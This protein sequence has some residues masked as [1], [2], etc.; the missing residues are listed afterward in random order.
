VAG[1]ERVHVAVLGP[2]VDEVLEGAS[3]IDSAG[4]NGLG[5][6]D[7]PEVDGPQ[8]VKA[9]GVAH[10]ERR[11]E[12]VVACALSV[13]AV[14]GPI[15]APGG[16]CGTGSQGDP[17]N[18]KDCCSGKRQGSPVHDAPPSSRA[19]VAVGH[20]A[21]LLFKVSSRR[22]DSLEMFAKAPFAPPEEGP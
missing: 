8:T 17:H 20:Y 2:D 12:G 13:E 6:H 9:A 1:I 14:L 19:Y 10:P 3:H 18:Q 4:E 16:S 11:L 21:P 15:D 22:V 5:D 7:V